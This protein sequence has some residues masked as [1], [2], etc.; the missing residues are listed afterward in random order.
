MPRK[1]NTFLERLLADKTYTTTTGNT[2]PSISYGVF[3]HVIFEPWKS[4]SQIVGS[5]MLEIE[6]LSEDDI[7]VA[8]RRLAAARDEIALERRKLEKLNAVEMQKDSEGQSVIMHR[9]LL[10]S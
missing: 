10:T 7:A 8:D 2:E 6:R 5:A 3:G 1:L 9:L 4:F